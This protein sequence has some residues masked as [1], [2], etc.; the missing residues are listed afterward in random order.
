MQNHTVIHHGSNKCLLDN[1]FINLEENVCSD[2]S[3]MNSEEVAVDPLLTW[4]L[5]RKEEEEDPK[6]AR[7]LKKHAKQ[8]IKIDH[9]AKAYLGL[10]FKDYTAYK[11][12]GKTQLEK[13]Q[14]QARKSNPFPEE[15]E[16][17]IA[18]FVNMKKYF[19]VAN[20][21]NIVIQHPEDKE[22]MYIVNKLCRHEGFVCQ[23]KINSLPWN[24][25]VGDITIMENLTCTGTYIFSLEK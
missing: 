2:V 11:Y 13:I 22:Y 25:K 24:P 10:P 1:Y 17:E 19:G 4:K 8:I 16:K 5:L 3:I 23:K 6:L 7:R 21:L 12:R 18:Q 20:E 14:I 15:A 9:A